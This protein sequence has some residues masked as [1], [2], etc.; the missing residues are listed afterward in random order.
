MNSKLKS[1]IIA[2]VVIIIL[3]IP[4]F[5]DYFNANK[6]STIKKYDSFSELVNKGGFIVSY[7]GDSSETYES[8]KEIMLNLKKQYNT[9]STPA[10]FDFIA[11]DKLS[12]EDIEKFQKDNSNFKKDTWIIYI[13]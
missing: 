6:I 7:V 13:I 9:D 8:K 10:E 4:I 5:V 3:L 2:I 11:F 12:D 1:W